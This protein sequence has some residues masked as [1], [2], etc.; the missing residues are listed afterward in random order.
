MFV[1]NMFGL[2]FGDKFLWKF[3]LA[4]VFLFFFAD[5]RFNVNEGRDY[6]ECLLEMEHSPC[7]M[8]WEDR[9]G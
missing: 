3:L 6:Q 8:T 5:Q 9:L 1:L 4:D 2:F 7:R